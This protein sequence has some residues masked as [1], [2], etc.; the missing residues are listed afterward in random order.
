MGEVLS[1]SEQVKFNHLWSAYVHSTYLAWERNRLAD[2][3]DISGIYLTDAFA[4][5]IHR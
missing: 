1:P 4:A 3:F 5:N 2:P